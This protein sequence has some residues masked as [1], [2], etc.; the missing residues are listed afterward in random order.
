[1]KR[2]ILAVMALGVGCGVAFALA[3]G[4]NWNNPSLTSNYTDV[5][6]E[7]K[8]RDVSS[9][10]MDYSSA[11]NLPTGVIRWSDS[12]GK[13][14]RWNGSSWV[15]L[16]TTLTAHLAN[17]SNPHSTT[18]AQ[19][20]AATT[21]SLSAHT[22]NTSNPHNVTTSQI[23]ALAKTS[24]LSDLNNAATAR[25][26]LGVPASSTVLLKSSNL[27]DVTDADTARF[28]LDAAKSGVNS[29]IQTLNQI[30]SLS[31]AFSI[32]IKSWTGG[33]EIGGWES[34]HR[35]KFDVGGKAIPPY[36]PDYTPWP[37]N[38]GGYTT[39]RSINPA[40]AT[41]ADCANAINTMYADSITQGLYQ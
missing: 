3:M 9:A 37:T 13:F 4:E 8:A 12:S 14:E 36:R 39:I 5:L 28:N 16:Q 26:N 24:N 21:A 33:V 7:L 15:D 20:G 27:S 25:S 10:K 40:A 1:M 17:T 19:V 18:A 29:D 23:G 22:S 6:T 34:N 38:L 35:W 32:I 30:S 2:K 11:T 31:Y 41:A